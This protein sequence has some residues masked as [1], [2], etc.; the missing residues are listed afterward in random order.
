[1][2]VHRGLYIGTSGWNYPHWKDTFY[3]GVKRKEWL[4]HY[5]QRFMSV[6]VNS[7]FYRLQELKTFRRWH[8]ETPQDFRFTIKGNR[9]LTHRKK[10]LD[11]HEPI[12][13]ERA[14][15]SG[16]GNKL[17][18]VVW[19]TPG[20]FH[21]N[22]P[23]LREFVRALRRWPETRHAVEFRHPSWFET[24]ISDILGDAGIANCLS[25]A[26]DWP[27]WD[28]VTT[29]LVYC[30]LHGHNQTYNSEYEDASIEEW[31][32]R[33]RHWLSE[34]RDVH[35]YFD[36]DAETRAPRDAMRLLDALDD[37]GRTQEP[38]D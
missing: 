19:Q 3:A 23:R 2:R 9:F 8:E 13:R 10:L 28:T 4:H 38:Q 22:V 32:G 25:D 36:N 5:A 15:A 17:A 24:E 12:Q 29:D 7:T 27:M 14:R 30:R 16:L 37:H 11:P 34:K 6:E 1:M 35:I 18:V 33:V 26:A 20:N 21:K 31:A